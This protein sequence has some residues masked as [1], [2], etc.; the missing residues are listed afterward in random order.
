MDGLNFFTKP[1]EYRIKRYLSLKYF[2]KH[3]WFIIHSFCRLPQTSYMH[4][5]QI[6]TKIH[7]IFSYTF[8][9][10]FE[11]FFVLYCQ[12]L[13][14]YTCVNEYMYLSVHP[15][16]HKEKLNCQWSRCG[17]E[18]RSPVTYSVFTLGFSTMERKK[19]WKMK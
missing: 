9:N 19:R 13:C 10:V 3:M 2:K 5:F 7:L 14:M 18:G 6:F 1:M 16:I 4:G 17:G 15:S 12:S 11:A 8:I